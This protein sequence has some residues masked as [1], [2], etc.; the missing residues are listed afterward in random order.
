MKNRGLTVT[1]RQTKMT[2]RPRVTHPLGKTR[3]W[4]VCV[5]GD[6]GH[7]Q[8]PSGCM[9]PTTSPAPH[10]QGDTHAPPV[11]HWL[12]WWSA[13]PRG[14]PCHVQKDAGA[15]QLTAEQAC[16]GLNRF[17]GPA[18]WPGKDRPHPQDGTACSSVWTR[19]HLQ[20]LS[21]KRAKCRKVDTAG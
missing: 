14:A 17:G 19:K 20:G 4:P 10:P 18:G 21:F 6:T 11:A 12:S 5:G 13:S 9:G 3:V 8:N 2:E 16:T 1:E 15:P 7:L